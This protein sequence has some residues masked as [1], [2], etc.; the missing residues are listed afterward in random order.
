MRMVLSKVKYK[1]NGTKNLLGVAIP[2]NTKLKNVEKHL[3]SVL[4]EY[5]ENVMETHMVVTIKITSFT[6][7]YGWR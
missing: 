4:T 2:W 3:V 7:K 6:I 1:V 5:H